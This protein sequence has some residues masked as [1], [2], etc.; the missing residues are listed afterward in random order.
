MLSNLQE[1]NGIQSIGA[2]TSPGEGCGK[3]TD[4]H[5]N[6]PIANLRREA[7]VSVE[8]VTPEKV[9]GGALPER[10]DSCEKIPCVRKDRTAPTGGCHKQ[11]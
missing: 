11:Y 5:R 8:Q 4:D 9:L 10:R 6:D 1:R 7:S 3:R 2:G